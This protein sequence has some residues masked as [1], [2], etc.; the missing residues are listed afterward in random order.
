MVN[1]GRIHMELG[2][3]LMISSN[4]I[5]SND[6]MLIEIGRIDILRKRTRRRIHGIKNH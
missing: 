1:M 2:K 4:L 5:K 3:F 6:E